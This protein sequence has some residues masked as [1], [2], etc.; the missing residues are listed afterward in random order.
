[1][2]ILFYIAVIL[3]PFQIFAANTQF[4]KQ[5]SGKPQLLQKGPQKNWCPV[6]GMNL[7]KFY[8]TNH[9]V[10]LDDGKYKQYCSIRCMLQDY[11][12]LHSIVK[13]ILVMDAKSEKFIHTENA[14]YVVG[15]KAPGTMT[16]TSKYAFNSEKDAEAFQKMMGGQIMRYRQAADSALESMKKDVAMTD[17]KRAKMMYP[18]GKKIY[19]TACGK[20]IDPFAYNL[21][22][23]LKADIRVNKKCGELKEPEL[24]AVAL[25]LW[26]VVRRE[27]RAGDFIK[28]TQKDKCPV[29]GMFV[30]KYPKWAAKIAYTRRG[31]GGYAVFDGVKDMMKF[32]FAPDKWGDYKGLS[33]DK[34]LVTD[35]YTNKAIDAQK[36][37]YVTGSDIYGPMGRELIPFDTRDNAETFMA[38]HS[39]KKILPFSEITPEMVYALDE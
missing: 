28:V 2:R 13:E 16:K 30:Y 6:C 39:G 3:L 38:D 4:T 34:I 25:Y 14:F 36:A 37:Y 11:E 15:S 10:K 12:G 31:C 18:K 19:E 8:K 21:I 22:N 20:S 9:A 17:I 33:I 32:Y 1:M 24:Q 7:K 5:A 29:C 23:E 27:V 26:D 35:Y